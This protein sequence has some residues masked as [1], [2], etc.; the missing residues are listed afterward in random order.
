[1][2]TE[3]LIKD[4]LIRLSK[5]TQAD[6]TSRAAAELSEKIGHELDTLERLFAAE[7]RN[8]HP[9]LAHFLA[10]RSYAKALDFLGGENGAIPAGA[11]KQN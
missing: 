3:A 7:R 6:S 11:R 10:N 9:Q 4:S 5:A 1:M 8:L 2:M